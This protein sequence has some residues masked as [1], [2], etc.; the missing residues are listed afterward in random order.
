MTVRFDSVPLSDVCR[1]QSGF[2]FKSADWQTNGV[3][4]VQIGN[5]KPRRIDLNGCKFVSEEVAEKAAKFSLRRDDILISMTGHIGVVGKVRSDE[6]I[7]LNQRVG[8]FEELNEQKILSSYLFQALQAEPIRKRLV[9]LGYGAAQ[10]N[11]SPRLIGTVEIPLPPLETQR[12]IATILDSYDDLIETNWRR[13]EVLEEVVRRLFEEWFEHFRFPGHASVPLVETPSGPMPEGWTVLALAELC[14]RIT[15]GAHH[16]PASADG[17]KPMA[18]VRDMR[19]WGFEYSD[20]R[21]IAEEDWD[22]LVRAD[23][24]PR[25]GDILIAKDGANLNKHT[26]LVWREEPVVLLSSIAVIRA[27]DHVQ[28][29]FLTAVLKSSR[30]DA[31]I[32]NMKSGAAIPRIVLKDFKRLPIV[33]PTSAIRETFER[34]VRPLHQQCRVLVEA[35]SRL[36]A[37]RDLLLPRLISRELTLETAE[38]ELEIAA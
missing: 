7:M 22:E 28:R 26:F 14:S 32:K 36:A 30:T 11:I 15:D 12:R 9:K 20:C 10:P 27:R 13:T 25:I 35:N 2:A 19:D 23:C 17:G 33:W 1:V 21:T 34:H 8:R 4:V 38:A 29:E 37:A 5:V 3:P 31:A 6:R 18:S 16:S 24:R